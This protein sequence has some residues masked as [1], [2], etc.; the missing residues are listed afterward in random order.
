MSAIEVKNLGKR[1]EFYK[2]QAGLLG[3]LKAFFHRKMLYTDAVDDISFDIE[4][5]E[6]VG[7]LGPNGAGKTTTLKML[8]GILYPTSGQMRV[9]GF[10]P[11]D[12]QKS[13]KK[14]FGIV[15]G[16]KDQL[17]RLLTPMDNF[18]LFKEFYE[19]PDSD[20]KQMVD[21]LVDLLGIR[22]I[23]DVQVKK[24]SLG[25]RMKCELVG[26]LLHNP[27]VL[28]LDE[29][30]IGLDVVAQK[31][32]RDFIK[33]YNRTKKTTIMLT[34]HYMDDIKELCE[35]VIIINFG[36]IIYDG[37]LSKL[38][39]TYATDKVVRITSK[40][41]IEKSA[42][43]PFGVVEEH[44][45]IRAAIRVPR[46]SVKKVAAQLISSNLPIEDILIDEMPVD[47][48]IRVIFQEQKKEQGGQELHP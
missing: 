23:L 48:I 17:A 4:E 46:E 9:L 28:F 43:E 21:E 42:L 25:Q 24:L 33:K 3:T 2:K 41:P 40:D 10:N 19:I 14:Q 7:F 5:G 30:T 31:N 39:S 8:S 1:Y 35:R 6:I 37:K 36:K 22:E 32:I 12:R 27:K 16:Q 38:I 13:F 20:F 15:M 26:A 44:E 47:D 18:A 11:A 29:P 45:N 34:S